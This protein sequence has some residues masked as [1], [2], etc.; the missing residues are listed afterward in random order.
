[1][2]NGQL[3]LIKVGEIAL[4]GLNRDFFEKRLKGNIKAKLRPYQ[5]YINQKGA[6][7]WRLRKP[8]L[9]LWWRKPSRPASVWS[10]SQSA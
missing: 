6:S 3:Y 7:S 2:K 8:A 1:M 5:S 9:P 10:A 4:K